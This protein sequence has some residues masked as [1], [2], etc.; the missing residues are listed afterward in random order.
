MNI[1]FQVTSSIRGRTLNFVVKGPE[2]MIFNLMNYRPGQA[3]WEFKLWILSVAA[4]PGVQGVQ[5]H[6]LISEIVT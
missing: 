6:P 4:Q 3:N 2:R 1:A 5:L